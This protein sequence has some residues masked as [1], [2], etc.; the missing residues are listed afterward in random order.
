MKFEIKARVI[1]AVSITFD[2]STIAQNSRLGLAVTLK[3]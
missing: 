2:V 1:E 3:L